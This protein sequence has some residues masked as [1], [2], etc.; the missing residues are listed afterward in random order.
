MLSGHLSPLSHIV[1]FRTKQVDPFPSTEF[2]FRSR[3][4]HTQ[5]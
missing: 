1:L 4:P 2:K 3:I 5:K